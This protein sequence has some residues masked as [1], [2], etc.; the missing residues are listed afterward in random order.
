MIDNSGIIQNNNTK[1]LEE[2]IM[3][4]KLTVIVDNTPYGN[5][6][7]EW[8]LSILSE[9]AGKKIL[10]DVGASELFAENMSKLGFDI[11]DID[12]G[13]LSHAH[14]DH[15][16]GM[17]RFFK[18]NHKAKFYLRETTGEN[19]YVKK[20]F[21]RKYIGIPKNVMTGYADRIEIVS[22]D[23]KLFEGAY[24]IPHKTKGLEAIGKREMMY[25]KT[26]RGW[27]ADD[28]SH[29]QSL[30][31]DTDKGL[32]IINCCS[33][34][35]AVNIIN[36]VKETFPDKGVYGLI[37]GFHL[38]NKS[39]DEV[40]QVA[41]KIL[42]TGIDF[43]CTGHCTKDKAYNIMKEELGDKLQQLRVG[44]EMIF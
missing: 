34:G 8:G 1:A 32:V 43:V 44:L 36:E 39:E 35:G 7:G 40:R 29:E 23:Y 6:K 31:L 4:T 37:G 38:Y 9:Y 21:F 13:V 3:E 27:K 16:N 25:Q 20:F 2:L 30:V 11:E 12:Y 41:K 24:L 18:E 17:P 10:V 28:F 22:G 26:L 14:Y 5:M 42:K 33:H 15:A 19:C